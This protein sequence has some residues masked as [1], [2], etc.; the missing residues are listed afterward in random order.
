[1]PRRT[2]ARE[3]SRVREDRALGLVCA[4]G[5]RRRPAR[6]T[7][8]ELLVVVA[9][10]AILAALLLP[11]LG[12]AKRVARDGLCNNNLRQLGLA[13]TSY[14][15]DQDD[16]YPL[17]AV[18]LG[19]PANYSR[20]HPH[21][22]K[23]SDIRFIAEYLGLKPSQFDDGTAMDEG[24][25]PAILRCPFGRFE[26]NNVAS[27]GLNNLAGQPVGYFYT[28]G[29][30]YWGMLEWL[31]RGYSSHTVVPAA[32]KRKYAEKRCDADA[33]LWGDTVSAQ[34]WGTPQEG[35]TH[36]IGGSGGGLWK[37]GTFFADF[38]RQNLCRVDGSVSP[39]RRSEVNPNP[40]AVGAGL[41]WG[42]GAP[43][44]YCWWY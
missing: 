42:W 21:D 24:Q 6:F 30:A 40:S 31:P 9:I 2:V 15:G 19:G 7:L 35:Y 16:S 14:T 39:R 4:M 38:D 44:A 22:V 5:P 36:T 26:R 17:P 18:Y 8:I 33:A 25:F 12:R 29:Y 1:M 41:T 28:P 10:I 23:A 3:E 37:P 34:D 27:L 20:A 11:A 43:Q 32:F 13:A